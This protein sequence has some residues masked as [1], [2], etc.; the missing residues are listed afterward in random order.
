VS[1]PNSLRL[2]RTRISPKGRL[3]QRESIDVALCRSTESQE[4]VF[5]RAEPRNIKP[6][7][8]QNYVPRNIS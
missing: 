6:H 8:R 2:V 4:P 5:W 3:I 1:A 7:P